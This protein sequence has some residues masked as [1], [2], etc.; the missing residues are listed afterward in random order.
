MAKT[1]PKPK[2]TRQCRTCGKTFSPQPYWVDRGQG[3]YCSKPCFSE[4]RRRPL[5]ERFWEHVQ[6][7]ESCWLWTGRPNS[8][9][10][11]GLTQSIDRNRRLILAH[12]LSWELHHGPIP[13]K[14]LVCHHCDNP[15]CV[16]PEHLFLGGKKE[17]AVDMAVK[18]RAKNGRMTKL[19]SEQVTIIKALY[20]TGKLTQQQIAD[21]IGTVS[22]R[23][24]SNVTTGT[25]W[26]YPPT[27]LTALQTLPR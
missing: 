6:K 26:K 7:T 25:R 12:R 8:F 18:G 4:G 17:N 20:K 22:R 1:G 23:T 15:I 11:G 21:I 24:I 2:Y 3:H 9:G 16:N 13:E 14:K 5:E 10:Y 27:S 19:N